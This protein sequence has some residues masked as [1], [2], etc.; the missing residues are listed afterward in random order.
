MGASYID[1]L[2]ADSTVIPEKLRP[3]YSEKIVYLPHSYY[4]TSYPSEAP[5]STQKHGMR[6]EFGLPETGFIYCCFNYNYKITPAVFDSWMRIIKSVPA[7]VLWLLED[8]ADAANNLRNEAKQQGVN[9]HRL[10]FAKRLPPALHIARHRAADLFLDTLPYNAHTTASD[11]LW[12]GLPVLTCTGEA[13]ASRVAASLLNA[14]QLPELI[15]E[16]RQEYE[17]LAIELALNPERLLRIKEKLANNRQNAPLFD[18]SRLVRAIENAYTQMYQRY[19]VNLP[20]AHLQ[21]LDSAN[22]LNSKF[23]NY[24]TVI[25]TEAEQLNLKSLF[26]KAFL[27]HQHNHLTEAKLRYEEI[28]ELQPTHFDA[29]HFAGVIAL[30]TNDFQRGIDQI[31]RALLVNPKVAAAHLNKGKGLSKLNQFSMALQCYEQAIE[32]EPDN[33]EAHFHRA[34]TLHKLEYHEAAIQSYDSAL[35]LNPN[36]AYLHFKRATILHKLKQYESALFDYDQAIRLKADFSDAYYNRGTLLDTLKQYEAALESYDKALAINPDIDF[37]PGRRLHISMKICNWDNT[38]NQCTQLIEKILLNQKVSPTFQVLAITDSLQVQRKA[39]EIWSNEYHPAGIKPAEIS[40][41]PVHD[42]IRLGYFSADFRDHAVSYLLANLFEIHDR[43]RFELTAFSFGVN[44]KDEMRK[45]LEGSFDQFI[46]VRNKSDLEIA[47]LARAMEIDIAIDLGGFTTGSRTGIFTCKAAPIQLSYI[48]YLGTL[49]V[50]AID[51]LIA[52]TTLI[53]PQSQP[54]Y[55]EKIIYLPCY[56]VNDAKRKISERIFTRTELGL[57]DAGFVYCCFNNNYKIT[58]A[59]FDSWMRILQQVTNSVLFLYAETESVKFNLKKA[60]ITR[61]IASDRLIF[62]NRLAPPD[63]LAR[64]R[65]ADLFLDTHPYNAGTTASDALWAGLPVL[66]FMGEAFAS[67]MA[68]SLLNAIQLPE[69]I[70][71]SREDYEALAI[72]FAR[73]PQR[74]QQIRQK[75]ARNR[76]STPLF[77]TRTFTRHLESA[78]YKIY[79]RYLAGLPPEHINIIDED[80]DHGILKRDRDSIIQIIK[81]KLNNALEM[82]QKNELNQ[83]MA[84]YEEILRLQPDNFN[85]LH[86]AGVIALQKTD[87]PKGAELIARAIQINPEFAPAYHNLGCALEAQKQY[88]AALQNFNKAISLKPDYQ[89]AY[90]RRGDVLKVLG[91]YEAAIESYSK[92]ITLNPVNELQYGAP[93][94]TVPCQDEDSAEFIAY[95]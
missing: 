20:P 89:D 50:S 76:L 15:T 1:Y 73:N 91:R 71:S 14:I 56:Q 33:A 64:F 59:T 18:T 44:T 81:S 17:A 19:Q 74:L 94:S 62:G 7:S 2:I 36:H 35:K 87:F 27:A 57:P 24:P 28:L 86:L 67:R 43:A 40:K 31:N 83:A 66:T 22:F 60:A 37:L 54:Y 4:P 79:E 45:R 47:Q 12:A 5:E 53:P 58:P 25:N 75:L 84:L 11:A 92:A 52:D 21:V 63:Y 42:K 41:Y 82:H 26:Q 93:P 49:C 69:L 70:T 34:V 68:A 38:E 23:L 46:D 77:D 16:T 80:K 55:S 32:L 51:Y 10:V 95:W 85:A 6:T 48:G 9:A 29:L 30:Q 13:L 88:E 78:Y 90:N 72:E 39:A 8:N 61:G 65:T 3:F